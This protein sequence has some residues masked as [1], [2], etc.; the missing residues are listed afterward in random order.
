MPT[1]PSTSQKA[2]WPELGIRVLE[3][4]ETMRLDMR[5]D[6]IESRGPVEP[7]ERRHY[8]PLVPRRS[9]RYSETWVSG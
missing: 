5:L 7:P 4:G 8:S 3:P 6:V 1:P 9:R 2:R